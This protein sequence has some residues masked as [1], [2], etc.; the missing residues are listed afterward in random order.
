MNNKPF[1]IASLLAV[2]AFPAVSY[3]QGITSSNTQKNTAMEKNKSAIYELY[4]KCFNGKDLTLLPNFIADDFPGPRGLKGVPAFK[5]N[6]EPLFKAFPDIHYELTSVVAAEDKVAIS[7]RWEGT[8]TTAYNQ[9]QPTGKKMSNEGM[10]IFTFRDGRICASTVQT[11]RLGF[12]QNMGVVPQDILTSPANSKTNHV[13]FIDKF[14]IPA[15]AI[16]EFMDRMTKNR[17]ILHTLPGFV[18][19]NAYTYK[20]GEGNLICVTVAE[21]Q[22]H[23]AIEQAKQTVQAEY[24]KEGF[25]MPAM[26]SRLH[27]T[28]ERGVYSSL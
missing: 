6:L 9:F 18:K 8:S 27:I 1:R 14:L 26:L 25:D 17:N 7:W 5:A 23:Q 10:A 12:L 15:P 20:D 2:L 16:S 4:E 11:D 13:F 3:A 28:M 21:W 19:D 22:D 24:Q